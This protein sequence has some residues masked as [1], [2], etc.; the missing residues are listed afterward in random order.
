ML[1][2][3]A[4]RPVIEAKVSVELPESMEKS[5]MLLAVSVRAPKA[6]T[7]VLTLPPALLPPMERV[8]PASV[9]AEVEF[10][11]FAAPVLPSSRVDPACTS[12]LVVPLR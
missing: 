8:P 12:T 9:S 10:T 6:C 5:M 3:L 11:E 1:S 2:V 4:L 7:E